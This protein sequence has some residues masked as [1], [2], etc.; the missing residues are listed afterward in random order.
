MNR[1]CLRCGSVLVG[2]GRVAGVLL[3]GL[4]PRPGR[5]RGVGQQERAQRAVREGEHHGRR[6]LDGVAPGR[7]RRHGLHRRDGPDQREQ[8]VHLVDQ[9]EQ[10]RPAAGLT[11]P[12]TARVEVVVGLVEQR[13]ADHGDDRAEPPAPHDLAGLGHDG[14]VVAVVAGQHRDACRLARLD[15]PGGAFDGVADRLLHDHRDARRDALQ[16]AVDVHL[17]RGRQD[18][19]VGLVRREQLV[20]RPVQRHGEPL[21]QL[22]RGRAGVDDRRQ[23]RIGAPGDLLDVPLPDQARTGHR[24]PWMVDRH[25]VSLRSEANDASITSPCAPPRPRLPLSG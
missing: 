5:G 9:V 6:V 22:R 14:R 1:G 15:Q 24:D 19:P 4:L 11:A 16:P 23:R 18:H 12:A 13:R 7:V 25:Q 10:D 8:V 17:V 21:G 3:R 2:I 20:Q